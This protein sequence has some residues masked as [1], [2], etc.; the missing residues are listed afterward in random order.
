MIWWPSWLVSDRRCFPALRTNSRGTTSN[1]A[2]LSFIFSTSSSYRIWCAR[3]VNKSRQTAQPSMKVYKLQPA[4]SR[5]PIRDHLSACGQAVEAMEHNAKGPT[6]QQTMLD[7]STEVERNACH[8]S[9]L[10]VEV[11]RVLLAWCRVC[12]ICPVWLCKQDSI[13]N[14]ELAKLS[15]TCWFTWVPGWKDFTAPILVAPLLEKS[16]SIEQIILDLS[17]HSS[18]S[19]SRRPGTKRLGVHHW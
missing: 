11:Q 12:G 4:A 16:R 1:A 9:I 17:E 19:R 18:T 8:A 14:R 6:F 7:E 10:D 13:G 3:R 5:L 15:G 2:R